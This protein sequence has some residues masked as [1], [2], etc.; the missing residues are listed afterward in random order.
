[1][2]HKWIF[3]GVVLT[4]L[5]LGAALGACVS[6][7]G[8][9]T[10]PATVSPSPTSS[11]ETIEH[12][13]PMGYGRYG[14]KKYTK[15]DY[16]LAMSFMTDNWQNMSVSDF[17]SK[18][19]NTKDETAYHRAEDAL[20]RVI[21]TLDE[22]DPNAGFLLGTLRTSIYECRTKHYNAC[23][24]DQLPQWDGFV[25]YAKY[26]DVYGDKVQ[27]AEARGDYWFRYRIGD[28]AKVTLAL[29]DAFLNDVNQGMQNF[30]DCQTED[31]LKKDKD[32]EKALT[33]EL[34]RLTKEY[35]GVDITAEGCEASY[36]WN[37]YN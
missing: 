12:T 11:V 9:D 27:I 13:S 20:L 23:V 34:V 19:L 3:T 28:E 24:H 14:I 6:S 18:L 21:W 33:A 4:T 31:N 10:P 16:D 2:K 8:A 1:M 32:I 25:E 5:L 17:N 29:R 36:Y 7:A 35:G 15:A 26:E 30:I 22:K 37:A